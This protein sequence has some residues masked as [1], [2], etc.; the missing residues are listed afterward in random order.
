MGVVKNLL[1][2]VKKGVWDN[3]GAGDLF[4]DFR[5]GVFHN[6]GI[7]GAVGDAQKGSR[8]LGQVIGLGTYPT[9]SPPPNPNASGSIYNVGNP[10]GPIPNPPPAGSYT[11]G[12]TGGITQSQ[13]IAQPDWA[14]IIAR[15]LRQ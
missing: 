7:S 6:T 2:D 12:V 10:K 4:G 14:A 3:S 11:N 5:T 15:A 13:P 9:I 1:G 8:Q